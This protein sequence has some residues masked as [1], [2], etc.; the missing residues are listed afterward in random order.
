MK[1]RTCDSCTKCCE[2]HLKGMAHGHTFYPGKPCH[3]LGT[4][5]SIYEDRPE[6]PCKV[7]KCTWLESDDLP[8]WMRPDLCHAI[9]TKRIKDNV[10]YYEVIEAGK[11]LDST[12]LSWFVLWALNNNHNLLYEVKGAKSRI[13]A[14]N[15][16]AMQL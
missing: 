10:T 3:F 9:T 5:C 13:G 6:T 2:G 4:G 15:F 1:E 14:S 12:I 16:L 7:Y 8:M 11:Q